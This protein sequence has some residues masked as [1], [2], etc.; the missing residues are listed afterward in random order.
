LAG[1]LT[2]RITAGVTL[3]PLAALPLRPWRLTILQWRLTIL[4]LIPSSGF[5]K[6]YDLSNSS[7]KL[8]VP[9]KLIDQQQLI[10]TQAIR[11]KI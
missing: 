11:T 7:A 3:F 9:R 1:A 2:N 8:F 6:L 4:Q 10:G 5:Q